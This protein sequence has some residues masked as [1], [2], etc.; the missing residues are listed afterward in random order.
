MVTPP[1]DNGAMGTRHLPPLFITQP[2]LAAEW[3]RTRNTIHIDEVS[4]ASHRRVWWSCGTCGWEWETEV[5]ARARDGARCPPCSG[6]SVVSLAESHPELVSEWHPLRNA[7]LTADQVTAGSHKR[8]WWICR[9]CGDCWQKQ[10]RRWIAGPGCNICALM[11]QARV[12][13]PV[14]T[15]YAMTRSD[16]Q[17]LDLLDVVSITTLHEVDTGLDKVNSDGLLQMGVEPDENWYTEIDPAVLVALDQL[18]AGVPGHL[19]ETT[20]MVRTGYRLGRVLVGGLPHH[21]PAPDLVPEFEAMSRVIVP[22]W[23]LGHY[24]PVETSWIDGFGSDLSSESIRIHR[25]WPGPQTD[26]DIRVA[27]EI[28]D[29]LFDLDQACQVAID[30]GILA[31]LVEHDLATGRSPSH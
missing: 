4:A 15:P 21:H 18:A 17:L 1:S 11:S 30:I 26:L 23:W 24:L 9:T 3:H 8:V 28:P 10:V 22:T 5:R 29:A 16:S 25:W 12:E 7:D 6:R 19:A 14:R 2:H 27:S 13:I 20:T 31:A